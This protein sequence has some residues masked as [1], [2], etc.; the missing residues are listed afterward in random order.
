MIWSVTASSAV[1]NAIAIEQLTSMDASQGRIDDRSDFRLRHLTY[2]GNAR[3]LVQDGLSSFAQ[4]PD[5]QSSVGSVSTAA[6][7]WSTLNPLHYAL[8]TFKLQNQTE[9]EDEDNAVMAEIE[10]VYRTLSQTTIAVS[11]ARRLRKLNINHLQPSHLTRVE[12]NIQD[13]EERARSINSLHT[14]RMN[15]I[16]PCH[17][18]WPAKVWP[19]GELEKLAILFTR[20]SIAHQKLEAEISM[21][22]DLSLRNAEHV[23][24]E[25]SLTAGS[26]PAKMGTPGF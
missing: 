1:R 25:K 21:L 11:T 13:V 14:E 2:A 7:F 12:A 23:E 16:S 26:Q 6:G 15:K 20:L 10:Q 19:M 22:R 5:Q 8:E 3:D 24:D 9:N 18:N 17:I 4:T